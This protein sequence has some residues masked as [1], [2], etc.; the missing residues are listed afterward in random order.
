MVLIFWVKLKAEN[1]AR[2]DLWD[3]LNTPAQGSLNI[4]VCH[5][6]QLPTR[7]HIVTTNSSRKYWLLLCYLALLLSCWQIAVCLTYTVCSPFINNS[8][9]TDYVVSGSAAKRT[10]SKS[11]SA[12]KNLK[13]KGATS[14]FWRSDYGFTGFEL[15]ANKIKVSY[16]NKDDTQVYTFTKENP[17]KSSSSVIG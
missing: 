16:I 11:S 12:Q 14:E 13:K 1:S 5:M 7:C 17:R 4:L 2:W 8:G 10:S 9:I 15:E 3:L 6:V